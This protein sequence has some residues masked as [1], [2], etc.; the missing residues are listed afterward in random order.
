MPIREAHFFASATSKRIYSQG[1]K[2]WAEFG[3][4]VAVC[5]KE[6]DIVMNGSDG[7]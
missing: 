6:H 4:R 2:V 3:S 5:S 7:W 1:R